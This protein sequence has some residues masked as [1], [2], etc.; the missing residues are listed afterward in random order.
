VKFGPVIINMRVMWNIPDMFED[1]EFYY[2]KW[3]KI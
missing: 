1:M 2:N 3:K